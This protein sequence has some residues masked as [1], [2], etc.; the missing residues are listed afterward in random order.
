MGL[1]IINNLIGGIKA[2]ASISPKQEI[3]LFGLKS[4]SKDTERSLSIQHSEQV[5]LMKITHQNF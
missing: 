1:S 4:S 2:G 3:T 5:L